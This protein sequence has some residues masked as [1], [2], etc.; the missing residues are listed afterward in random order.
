MSQFKTSSSATSPVV[1]HQPDPE[2]VVR[3]QR[4]QFSAAYKLRILQEADECKQPGQVG[5]LLRREGLY[6]SQLSDWRQE[7]AKGLGTQKRGRKSDKSAQENTALRQENVRLKAQ[8][9]Q[10][11]LIISAQKKLAQVL[12]QSL[13]LS[14]GMHW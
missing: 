6:A 7:R 1:N 4:R 14:K 10:A 11:D 9:A 8:L 5:A 2:V 12:E 3:A 13:T